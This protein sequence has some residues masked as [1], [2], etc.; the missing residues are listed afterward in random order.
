MYYL[1]IIYLLTWKMGTMKIEN[2][3]LTGFLFMQGISNFV[4]DQMSCLVKWAVQ[5]LFGGDGGGGVG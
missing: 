2:A 1:F 4:Y 5:S 3:I